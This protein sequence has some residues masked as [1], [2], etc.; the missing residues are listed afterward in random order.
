MKNPLIGF[1]MRTDKAEKPTRNNKQRKLSYYIDGRRS[2]YTKSKP[3]SKILTKKLQWW[4]SPFW[5][6][7]LDNAMTFTVDDD[8]INWWTTIKYDVWCRVLYIW[9]GDSKSNYNMYWYTDILYN[10]VW[11]CGHN[12]V[13]LYP[14]GIA[15]SQPHHPVPPGADTPHVAA[16]EFWRKPVGC[17][18]NLWVGR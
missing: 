4:E 18:T 16:E 15:I 7:S 1:L 5:K 12:L 14:V 11:Y 13:Y 9:V 6:K 3:V 17:C 10:T 2:L 8:L